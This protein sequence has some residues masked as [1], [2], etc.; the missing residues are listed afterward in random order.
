MKSLTSPGS[1][2][3]KLVAD[4]IFIPYLYYLCFLPLSFLFSI[5][6]ILLDGEFVQVVRF[7]KVVVSYEKMLG[8]QLKRFHLKVQ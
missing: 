3:G 4:T 2:K 7:W 6:K 5:K 1:A 8:L